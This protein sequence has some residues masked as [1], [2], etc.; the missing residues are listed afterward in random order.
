MVGFVL[1]TFPGWLF[2]TVMPHSDQ[3]HLLLTLSLGSWAGAPWAAALEH[4]WPGFRDAGQAQGTHLHCGSTAVTGT[5][6][7]G[8]ST[9]VKDCLDMKAESPPF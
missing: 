4:A 6:A 2:E 3:T 8:L 9:E 7:N 5:R 1:L